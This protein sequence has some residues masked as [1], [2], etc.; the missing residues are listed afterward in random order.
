MQSSLIRVIALSVVT[1]AFYFTV[2]APTLHRDLSPAP[3]I[4]AISHRDTIA[5]ENDI[6]A[7]VEEAVNLALGPGGMANL[8]RP[9]DRVFIKINANFGAVPGGSN[10]LGYLTDPRVVRAVAQLVTQVVPSSQVQVGEGISHVGTSQLVEFQRGGYDADLNGEL[11]GVPGVQLICL[12]E[13]HDPALGTNPAYVTRVDNLPGHQRTTVYLPNPVVRADVRITIPVF[14]AHNEA[15][16]TAAEKNSIGLAPADIYYSG[17]CNRSGE[18]RA[19]LHQTYPRS[20]A[21]ATA[22][23]NAAAPYHLAVVDALTAHRY[24]PWASQPDRIYP[25]AILAGRDAVAVDTVLALLAGWDPRAIDYLVYGQN[26]GL[27]TCDTGYIGIRGMSVDALRR[28]VSTQHPGK[29][30]FPSG[31]GS[32]INGT[33]GTTLIETQP[34]SVA[35]IEPLAGATVSGL[36]PVRFRWNDNNGVVRA[37]LV[38]DGTT[39]AQLPYPTTEDTLT[40]DAW[41]VSAGAHELAVIVYD[42]GLAQAVARVTVHVNQT[43]AT[44]SFF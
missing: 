23:L 39:V 20:A 34:P 37:E 5:G 12:N 22:D 26:D 32:G 28:W 36:V 18:V 9:T 2:S 25:R 6:R 8:I 15:G 7:M 10:P 40:W 11:D 31:Y 30:P 19:A 3:A 16:L 4:V 33:R 27:G 21:A 38:A 44:L 24:G 41:S 13:P 43:P 1:A 14:K 17:T 35:L 29:I 42:A